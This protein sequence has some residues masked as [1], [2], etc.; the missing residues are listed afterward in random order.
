[1][2]YKF[3]KTK[4][5]I[6][7]KKKMP[8]KTVKE[9]NGKKVKVWVPDPKRKVEAREELEKLLRKVVARKIAMESKKA[10]A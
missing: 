2:I 5:L 3:K 10:S 4:F 1:M 8:I 7:K 6:E 9:F